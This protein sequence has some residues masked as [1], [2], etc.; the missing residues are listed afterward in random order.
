MRFALLALFFLAACRSPRP[1]AFHLS[2]TL[3]DVDMAGA[4]FDAEGDLR[5]ISAGFTWN[6]TA[7]DVHRFAPPPPMPALALPEPEP[8]PPVVFTEP[9]ERCGEP[10]QEAAEDGYPLLATVMWALGAAAVLGFC[11]WWLDSARAPAKP[12]PAVPCNPCA[13]PRRKA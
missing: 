11:L 8:A 5:A 7:P 9:A 6:L 10:T 3:G 12:K 1:D 4:C 2:G 13:K